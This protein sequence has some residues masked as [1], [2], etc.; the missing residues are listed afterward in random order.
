MG[1]PRAGFASILCFICWIT[2]FI[3][4]ISEA[5]RASTTAVLEAFESLPRSGASEISGTTG[6]QGS[7]NAILGP[8]PRVLFHAERAEFSR[9]K[10]LGGICVR[11]RSRNRSPAGPVRGIDGDLRVGS[12][13]ARLRRLRRS[14]YLPQARP[15]R[16]GFGI[17]T[18][19]YRTRLAGL[20]VLAWPE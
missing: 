20:E 8:L 9:R 19:S 13:S 16:P 6:R 14:G 5:L 15:R 1:E 17:Q 11:R 7:R 3:G 2:Y 4:A 10:R 18:S 12:R